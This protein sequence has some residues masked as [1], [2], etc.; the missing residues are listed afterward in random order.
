MHRTEI[1]PSWGVDIGLSWALSWQQQ[2]GY[3]LSKICHDRVCWTK[4]SPHDQGF[5][6]LKTPLFPCL[7]TDLEVYVSMSLF[8]GCLMLP[9]VLLYTGIFPIITL[10]LINIHC[11]SNERKVRLELP[12]C[13]STAEPQSTVWA[14]HIQLFQSF[15]QSTPL[16]EAQLQ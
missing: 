4:I 16:P 10:S 9:S 13:S 5:G 7:L 11:G 1:D 8:W 3:F 14:E 2:P 6:A 12:L 15:S